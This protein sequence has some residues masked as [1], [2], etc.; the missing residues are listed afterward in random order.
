M[1]AAGST[2]IWHAGSRPDS[3]ADLTPTTTGRIGLSYSKQSGHV[4]YGLPTYLD[5]SIV[6]LP[7]DRYLGADWDHLSAEKWNAFAEIEQKLSH[8]WAAKLAYNHM[9]SSQHFMNGIPGSYVDPVTYDG[10]PYSYN[11]KDRNTQDAVDAYASGPFTLFGRK[12]QLT[13]G[14]NYLHQSDRSTQYFINP[15]SGLD[16]WGDFFTS[17]LD[18]SVYSNDF[19]G[20]PQND[21]RTVTNQY[22][23]YGNA[24]FNILDP[25]TLIVGGRATWWDNTLTPNADPYYNQFGETYSHNRAGP[26]VTPLAG[27]VY[28]INNTY[29]AYASYTSIYKPQTS[30]FT[31]DGQMIKPVTGKQYE[32]G[33]KGEYFGGKLN[34]SF[35][36]FQID[37]TNRAFSDPEHVGFYV[38]QGRAR[39]QGVELTAS[40]EVL[41]GLTLST[42]YTYVAVRSLDQSVT[43]STPFSFTPRH[44][45][46]L[47]ANYQLPGQLHDWN[48]GGALYA[49]SSTYF[50]DGVGDT[51]APGYATIDA[52]VGYQFSKKL[53]ASLSVTNLLDRKYFS[54]VAGA[55]GNYYGNPAKVLLA[56]HYKM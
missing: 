10:N 38:A 42:G 40:G 24:R 32:I 15:A 8:G 48:V 2:S 22:G 14:A 18:T 30:F 23:V 34:T 53:S 33:L 13:I 25:L 52:T 1:L 49:T 7:R 39:S 20:G 19:A 12:H 28:D 17:I 50:S 56:L 51:V 16:M 3:D 27:L 41:P 35:A 55:A 26:K 44:Q 36:L 29:S 6:A 43:S 47:W 21:F 11:Y 4:M 5:Y 9:Q 45:F 46:K 54:T 31:Y 37:E